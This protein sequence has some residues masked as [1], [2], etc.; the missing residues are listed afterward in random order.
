M[1]PNV[2]KGVVQYPDPDK[3]TSNVIGGPLPFEFDL[4]VRSEERRAKIVEMFEEV[5]HL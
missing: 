2:K 5:A 3:W 4:R 1:K